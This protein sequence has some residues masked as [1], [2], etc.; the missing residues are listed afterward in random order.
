MWMESTFCTCRFSNKYYS[1]L[2]YSRTQLVPVFSCRQRARPMMHCG[3]TMNH[4]CVSPH[5]YEVFEYGRRQWASTI[6]WHVRPTSTQISLRMRAV[7]S[8]SS[9]SA[10][11][12]FASLAIQNASSDD[13]DQTARM[14]SLICIF[15]GRICPKVSFLKMWLTYIL[16]ISLCKN[17]FQLKVFCLISKWKH[18]DVLLV[19]IRS[20]MERRIYWLPI[21]YALWGN[22][23]KLSR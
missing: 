9:L 5:L 21:T 17:L 14:R 10:W 8:E 3:S 22:I 6:F 13:S 12:N 1:I 18:D 23:E 4:F 20:A 16:A 7:W 11:R 15:A 19:L 2:F